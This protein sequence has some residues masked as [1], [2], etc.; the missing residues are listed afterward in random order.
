MF[1]RLQ[2]EIG[3]C[4]LLVLLGM[5]K[6]TFNSLLS[7]EEKVVLQATL[8]EP[9]KKIV[10]KNTFMLGMKEEIRIQN[11]FQFL[12]PHQNN[13]KKAL[14]LVFMAKQLVSAMRDK[15]ITDKDCLSNIRIEMVADLMSSITLQLCKRLS[16]ELKLTMQKSLRASAAN[17]ELTD[18]FILAMLRRNTISDGLSYALG[19]GNWDTRNVDTRRYLPHR[20]CFCR[21]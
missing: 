11:S 18:K 12:L 19:T 17:N 9:I 6:K 13:G 4:S 2:E 14:Y 10:L 8:N 21:F 20:I 16:S 1:P 15:R 7:E 5:T 3:L